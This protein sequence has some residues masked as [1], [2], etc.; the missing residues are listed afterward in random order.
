MFFSLLFQQYF[1]AMKKNAYRKHSL[2]FLQIE[3]NYYDK[4]LTFI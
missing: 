2:L 4:L 3:R 1:I